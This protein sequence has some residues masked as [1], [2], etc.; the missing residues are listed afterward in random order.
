MLGDIFECICSETVSIWMKQQMHGDGGR[1]KICCEEFRQILEPANLSTYTMHSIGHFITWSCPIS[2]NNG[3][4]TQLSEC[5]LEA[6][7]SQ[8]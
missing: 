5:G 7:Q 4:N 6:Y 2:I 8:V 3:T 1:G